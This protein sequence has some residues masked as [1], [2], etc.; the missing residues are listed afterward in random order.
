MFK[1]ITEP[2]TVIW[3]LHFK[4]QSF[5]YTNH[6]YIFLNFWDMKRIWLAFK[7]KSKENNPPWFASNPSHTKSCHFD[8]PPFSLLWLVF[9]YHV[10]FTPPLP[11]FSSP[12]YTL[13]ETLPRDDLIPFNNFFESVRFLR[14]SLGYLVKKQKHRRG[15]LI[16]LK[17]HHNFDYQ[18]KLT[19]IFHY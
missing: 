6:V 19:H 1:R 7:L 16:M 12:S 4:C 2:E 3:S 15:S 17:S 18:F 11:F 8:V 14:Y 13:C 9:K 5:S 10:N